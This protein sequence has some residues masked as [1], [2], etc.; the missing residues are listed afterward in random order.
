MTSDQPTQVAAPEAI[1]L[2]SSLT[3]ADWLRMASGFSKLLWSIPLGLLLFTGAISLRW[4]PLI[5]LPSYIVAAALYFWG[6]LILRKVTPFS[7]AWSHSLRMALLL[8]FLLFYFSPFIYWW[9][10]RPLID[11]LSVNV[12]ALVFT[13]TWILWTIN[14]LVE[15]ISNQLNDKV[16]MIEARLCRWSVGLFMIIPLLV[17]LIL[18]TLRA[19]QHGVPLA[20]FLHNLLYARHAYLLFAGFVMPM[21]LTLTMIWRTKKRSIAQVIAEENRS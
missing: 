15:V 1:D 16:F 6:L 9:E 10:R 8:G 17:F 21:T 20:Q 11:H 13:V 19:S 2:P 18:S 14:T 3:R 4:P 12:F 7:P 5:Q